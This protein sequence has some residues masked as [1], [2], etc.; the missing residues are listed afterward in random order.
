[1]PGRGYQKDNMIVNL[2][3]YQDFLYHPV[4]SDED[5]SFLT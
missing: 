2:N 3:L 4:G 5:S 1:M